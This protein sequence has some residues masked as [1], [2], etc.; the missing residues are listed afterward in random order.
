MRIV[1]SIGSIRGYEN[2]CTHLYIA[3]ASFTSSNCLFCV[4]QQQT[5][6][7]KE[8]RRQVDQATCEMFNGGRIGSTS[9]T[10][11]NR[12]E[13]IPQL[14]RALPY[15]RISV[16][17][18]QPD[19]L[20]L[21]VRHRE[22]PVQSRWVTSSFSLIQP[23]QEPDVASSREGTISSG[24]DDEDPLGDLE[25]AAA[26]ES[27]SSAKHSSSPPQDRPATANPG[28][29]PT[30]SHV[31]E[32]RHVSPPRTPAAKTEKSSS[33]AT[34]PGCKF[35]DSVKSYSKQSTCST[36][37]EEWT[38]DE[39]FLPLSVRQRHQAQRQAFRQALTSPPQAS[40]FNAHTHAGLDWDTVRELQQALSHENSIK[41]SRFR[42]PGRVG[43]VRE[44]EVL[45][46]QKE[47]QADND[48]V[49]EDIDPNWICGIYSR[50]TRDRS[51][52]L[53]PSESLRDSVRG[54]GE[55]FS[56]SLGGGDELVA[57]HFVGRDE[58][59]VDI[60]WGWILRCRQAFIISFT[61]AL[62][63]PFKRPKFS[64]HTPWP[65][66]IGLQYDPDLQARLCQHDDLIWYLRRPELRRQMHLRTLMVLH[67]LMLLD[68]DRR[69]RSRVPR[70]SIDGSLR[71]K[72]CNGH[73]TSFKSALMPQLHILHDIF[74]CRLLR[75]P[76]NQLC[77]PLSSLKRTLI[78]FIENNTQP[79]LQKLSRYA[80]NDRSGDICVRGEARRIE[81]NRRRGFLTWCNGLCDVLCSAMRRF[82]RNDHPPTH[83]NRQPKPNA[84][85][86]PLGHYGVFEVVAQAE[87]F[88]VGR[89]HIVYCQE[90]ADAM[91][92][93]SGTHVS[94]DYDVVV[95]ESL[96]RVRWRVGR[97][98]LF[99]IFDCKHVGRRCFNRSGASKRVRCE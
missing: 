7:R 22:L 34:S 78:Q 17:V 46:E 6:E 28:N 20:H 44:A 68:Q 36:S 85:K 1:V 26:L 80:K 88:P 10:V 75:P 96:R 55:L 90:Q 4:D 32:D 56:P 61:E 76:L 9:R 42:K 24:I 97:N 91:W 37:S 67:Q 35:R 16:V 49:D 92:D 31:S 27:S 87:N 69:K 73:K 30:T 86:N 13:G 41:T 53:L 93:N 66:Q 63:D 82:P 99:S 72:F 38:G 18:A 33:V 40:L 14:L 65:L 57:G 11:A 23:S 39:E 79:N 77:I 74:I 3:V 84:I 2:R 60:H 70:S 98:R 89:E 47:S 25:R 83:R 64:H 43:G 19:W 48:F 8:T 21:R 58:E 29:V 95:S 54:H 59:H 81:R 52:N 45:Q 5:S 50:C 62:V 12:V 71:R 51:T 15:K 94:Y